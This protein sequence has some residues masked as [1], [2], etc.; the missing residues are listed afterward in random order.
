MNN[1]NR[2]FG[3]LIKKKSASK[4]QYDLYKDLFEVAVRSG[5]ISE[6]KKYEEAKISVEKKEVSTT[7]RYSW[8]YNGE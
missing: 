4:A 3:E 8:K 2:E 6:L 5:L 7:D 1:R